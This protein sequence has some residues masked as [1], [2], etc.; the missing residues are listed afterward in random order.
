V[1]VRLAGDAGAAFGTVGLGSVRSHRSLEL[2]TQCLAR[3]NG[4]VLHTLCVTIMH[5]LSRPDRFSTSDPP[6]PWDL[7]VLGGLPVLVA[8][9]LRACWS[10]DN[11][12]VKFV[13][14]HLAFLSELAAVLAAVPGSP[15]GSVAAAG[16]GAAAARS[17]EASYAAH[18]LPRLGAEFVMSGGAGAGL[19]PVASMSIMPNPWSMPRLDALKHLRGFAAALA[20]GSGLRI[21]DEWYVVRTGF[22]APGFALMHLFCSRPMCRRCL[23]CCHRAP[24]PALRQTVAPSPPPPRRMCFPAR[25]FLFCCPK[26]H[27]RESLVRCVPLPD[28]EQD[29]DGHDW[30]WSDQP[31]ALRQFV[32]V[33]GLCSHGGPALGAEPGAPFRQRCR[34]ACA[35]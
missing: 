26:V 8:D 12:I 15:T 5:L 9:R 11:N 32:G 1:D 22:T 29:A 3:V 23:C 7:P 10:D 14:R 25:C 20:P 17:T 31:G 34:R 28:R 16:A 4:P 19:S 21:P 13:P 27:L 18:G 33:R 6:R 24:G 2:L 35:P 30:G